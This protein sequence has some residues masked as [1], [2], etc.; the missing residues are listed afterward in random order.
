VTALDDQRRLVTALGL[1]SIETHISYVLLGGALAYKIKKAVNLE[2]LDFSTLDARRFFCG[3]ELRLNRRLAPSLYLDVVPVTGTPD[4][5]V[6]GGDGE[7]IEY[8]VKMRQF[9]QEGLLT[10]VL[11]RG[12]LT[13]E[14][15]DEIA[16]AI[17]AFHADAA[18]AAPD[19]PYGQPAGVLDPARQNF[20]QMLESVRDKDDRAH[21]ERLRAWT[22]TEAARLAAEFARR[23][24]DGFVR[25]CHGDLHLGNIA[26][27]DDRVTLFDCIEFNPSMRWIDVM[28]DVAFLVMDLRDH[29]RA[30]LASRVLNGYLES[31]GDY[32]GLTVLRFYVIYRALVRA[33]IAC[34]RAAQSA[35]D[36]RAVDEYR[37]YLALATAETSPGHRGLFITHGV[38][39]SGKTT[40]A[41]AIVESAGAIRIR[42]DVERK[43]LLGLTTGATTG[44]PVGGG[45]YTRE[46]DRRTYEHLAALAR[47]IVKA[48]YAVVVDAAFLQRWQRDL[49]RDVATDVQVPFAI[50]DCT[51]PEAVLRERVRQ[52]Q[53][54]GRD[55]SEAT[56]E[57]LEHQLASAEPLAADE[58]TLR[59]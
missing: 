23:N 43:R 49:L 41:R 39:G 1:P 26:L 40:R 36:A 5:P 55:A 15:I 54:I 14:R 31:T 10:R 57:V 32:H 2:F 58:L 50:A 25:E 29:G 53:L 30:A 44:S 56:I 33:K 48:G 28:S 27:V 4:A 12:E 47:D 8:A 17:A 42:S 18:R 52:R 37:T 13:P 11:E 16:A 45:A 34:L 21:L 22:E 19:A 3:E 51:A 7:P 6:L 46:L 24:R 9:D 59:Q 35:G 20:V 38:T